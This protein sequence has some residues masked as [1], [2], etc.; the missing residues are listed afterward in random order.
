MP[1][2]INLDEEFPWHRK[3]V[4]LSDAAFR[5]HLHAICWASKN[6]T[7][8]AIPTD[9]LVDVAPR[10]KRRELLAE[11]LV[12]ADLWT[13][14]GHL[15]WVINDFLDYN[16]SSAVR[17]EMEESKKEAGRIGNHKRWHVKRGITDPDC[18]YCMGGEK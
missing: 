17:A 13:P 10:L 4:R 14:T 11:Q 18:K 12:K 16:P 1:W 15:G 6:R 5:L 3:L 7:D 2:F 8:G 9:D